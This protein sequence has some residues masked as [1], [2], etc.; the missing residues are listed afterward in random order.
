[1]SATVTLRPV[2]P[3]DEA[4]LYEVYASTRTE[5]LAPLGWDERQKDA[6]LR[7]QFTAQHRY[8]QAQFADAGFQIILA[9]DQPIGR[10]YV[11]RRPDEICLLDIALLPP[12]RNAGI[13]STLVKELLAEAGRL[14]KRVRLHVERFNPALR[15][16]ERLGFTPIGD[17][18]VYLHLERPPARPEANG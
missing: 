1:M 17:T 18:G 14:G 16:Y 11:H 7:M 8:Y 9:A 3:D 13:G 15:L 4:F 12:Y 10:L 2:T 6:F 5:E